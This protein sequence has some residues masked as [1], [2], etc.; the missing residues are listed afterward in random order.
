MKSILTL[1]TA[2]LLTFIASFNVVFANNIAVNNTK[3]HGKNVA[4]DF[5]LC[6]CM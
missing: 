5:Q 4:N 2:L 6:F 1:K 3:I